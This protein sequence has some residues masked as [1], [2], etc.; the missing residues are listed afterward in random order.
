MKRLTS[1]LMATLMVTAVLFASLLPVSA[2]ETTAITLEAPEAVTYVGDA[3]KDFFEVKAIL[4]PADGIDAIAG[5]RVTLTWDPTLLMP[6][7]INTSGEGFTDKKLQDGSLTLAVV[8]A[9][10]L[11]SD[12]LFSV[13]F[14]P[15]ADGVAT[16]DLEV[17]DM[18][19]AD[20]L[21]EATGDSV[22]IKTEKEIPHTHEYTSAVTAEPTLS[23]E[24]VITYT[25]E[26]GDTY[27]E[28][29]PAIKAQP[30]ELTS[31]PSGA[32]P[33]DFAGYDHTHVNLILAG[34]GMTVRELTKL[35]F[36]EEK[37]MNAFVVII[38]GADGVVTEINRTIGRPDGVK[39]DM[40]CPAGGYIIGLN[41]GRATATLANDLE[42]GAKI[43]LYNIDLEAI[44]GIAGNTGVESAGFTYENPPKEPEFLFGDVTGDGKVTAVDY[45]KLKAH[46]LNTRSLND[47][48][49][50]RSDING[51]GKISAVDYAQLKRYIL[52][53]WKPKK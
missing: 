24:G 27:T 4:N 52:G 11:L 42:V 21:I 41:S 5:Y 48:E 29:I 1:L 51:D 34:D 26:C 46:I 19:L 20:G 40:V 33:F 50:L 38:V 28:S 22:S 16:V 36:G 32:I 12:R 31:L 3:V 10:N 30:D 23:T 25:C 35:G 7:D 45:A 44:R 14:I 2:A 18:T 17:I 53:T 49:L 9:E 15:L 13:S 43:T 37:D 39:Y 6:V 47:A 8:N